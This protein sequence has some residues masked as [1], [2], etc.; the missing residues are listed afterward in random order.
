MKGSDSHANELL[1]WRERKREGDRERE[2]QSM[3]AKTDS[4]IISLF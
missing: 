2:S 4:T 1:K 3:N